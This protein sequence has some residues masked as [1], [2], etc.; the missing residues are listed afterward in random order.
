[1]RIIPRLAAL[2]LALPPAGA[3]TPD[4]AAPLPTDSAVLRGALPN[5]LRYIIRRN[6]K[7]EH[8]A[9]LR[10]V[11]NAGS[12]LE[13]DAQR[14]LAHFVEHMAF[15][16]TRR[17]PR[18]DI[19]NFVERV[20]MRFGADLNASTSFDET[21]Y[22]LQIPT[23]T[24]RRQPVRRWVVAHQAAEPLAHSRVIVLGFDDLVPATW[25]AWHRRRVTFPMR[26]YRSGRNSQV[27]ATCLRTW[28]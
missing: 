3:Q 14:G 22:T 15:N 20:G 10:L 8:R 5:G 12:I 7:P 9:E 1:M 25:A 17:F 23:D 6:G 24:A 18:G 27:V 28:F 19:V 16:G 21:V 13:D 4:L 2:L 11:V 26:L